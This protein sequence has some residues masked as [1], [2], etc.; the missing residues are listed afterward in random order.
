[1]SIFETL[2]K[3]IYKKN[4]K[5]KFLRKIMLNQVQILKDF[6]Q[7][8]TPFEGQIIT[9]LDSAATTLKTQGVIDA[10]HTYYAKETANIHRG[11]HTLSEVGT[12]KYEKTRDLLKDFINAKSRSEIIF[13]KGTTESIN[14]V[15]RSWGEANLR[16]HDEILISHME[17]HSNIVPW[18]ML[19]EKTG[20]ILKV[21]PINDQGEI[22]FEEYVKLLSPKTKLVSIMYVSNALGTINPI[23]E[24]IVEAKKVGALFLVDA[25]QAVAHIKIDV[26]KLGCDF[27]AFS[28]HKMFGPTGIGA[29]YGK[30][31][32]L[33]QMPPFLGGGDMIDRVSLTKT[34][35]NVLPYKFEAGTP[36]IAAGI[37]W[38][39]A[40]EY[41]N[42]LGLDAIAHYEHDL[43]NYATEKL[44]TIP[45]LKII[46][47]AK[48]KSAVISFTLQ[49]IHPQDIASLANKYG[50][51]LRTGHH[52]TQPLMERMCV[53][54]T[55]RASFSI[56][57]TKNDID[58]LHQTLLNIV[59]LFS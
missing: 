32:I 54:A 13:T 42:Q 30:E 16:P 22:I 55:A 2:F 25:A 40:I 9:Y 27:M 52:C 59:E 7:V 20:A 48:N 28:A 39:P 57:N 53:P 51:A 12:T 18:Q 8:S 17:H 47:L 10:I 31:E 38:A 58:K 6:P 23:A 50:V 26:Q 36:S 34:T 3:K 15:A 4:L 5:A 37:A 35:Y 43:L 41:I 19:C 46:G 44:L 49:D 14:L 56:Y 45:G 24:L 33:N 1:M 29:L 21:A 11:I